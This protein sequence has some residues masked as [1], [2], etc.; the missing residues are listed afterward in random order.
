M[1][2]TGTNTK[3]NWGVI[4]ALVIVTILTISAL[5]TAIAAREGKLAANSVGN[6]IIRNSDRFVFRGVTVEGNTTLGENASDSLTINAD[7]DSSIIPDQDIAYDLGSTN[8]RWRTIY[9]DTVIGASVSAGVSSITGDDAITVSPADGTGAVTLGLSIAPSKGLI[10]TAS[11][12]SVVLGSGL[13]FIGGGICVQIGEGLS[14][15][16]NTIKTTGAAAGVGTRTAGNGIETNA[17]FGNVVVGVS[18]GQGS[19][20]SGAGVSVFLAVGNTGLHFVDND[21]S[22]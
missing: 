15:D 17:S 22:V 6:K 18:G 2:Y 16:G 13:D 21:L 5:G 20:V 8:Q 19:C 4:S 11:G 10:K 1:E 7:L 3:F 12:L 9:A 14:F